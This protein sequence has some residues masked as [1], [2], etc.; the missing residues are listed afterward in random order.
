MALMPNY[1]CTF[2][3]PF[4]FCQIQKLFFFNLLTYLIF[5]LLKL[6]NYVFRICRKSF[7]AFWNL[8][9]LWNTMAKP[10]FSANFEADNVFVKK[11][12]ENLAYIA[13]C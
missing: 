3:L 2:I 11:Q 7:S 10:L 12:N 9:T 5:K 1:I 13:F 6:S 4:A 8:Q